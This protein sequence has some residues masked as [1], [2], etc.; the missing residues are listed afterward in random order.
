MKLADRMTLGQINRLLKIDNNW[1]GVT[2]V[3]E[4]TDQDI[5][6]ESHDEPDL[7]GPDD[8]EPG[9]DACSN[10]GC[11]GKHSHHGEIH[12]GTDG[13]YHPEERDRILMRTYGGH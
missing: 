5:R 10:P 7:Y 8:E 11:P 13:P 2:V 1:D 3:D 4:P 6:I 9:D 12:S